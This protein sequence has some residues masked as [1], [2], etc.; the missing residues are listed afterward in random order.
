MRFIVG[1]QLPP[2]LATHL[3][4]KGFDSIHTT[5]FDAGHLL[6][7]SEIIAIAKKEL[8]IVI[9]K[10]ADFSDHYLLK[11]APPKVL[12]VEFGNINNK[13]LI[14]LFDIHFT[15]IIDAFNGGCEM[16]LFRRDEIVK[17]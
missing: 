8:R 1:T 2:R 11:G 6:D 14:W 12:L 4:Q 5:Y 10:D 3:A 7:D 13:E 17:Y 9:T 15:E 16:V